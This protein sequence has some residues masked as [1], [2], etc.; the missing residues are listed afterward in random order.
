M[1]RKFSVFKVSLKQLSTRHG[2]SGV[3]KVR[4]GQDPIPSNH[5]FRFEL[6]D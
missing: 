4:F 5:D 1:A 2:V 3:I 6:S